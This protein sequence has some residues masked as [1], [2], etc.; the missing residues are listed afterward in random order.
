MHAVAVYARFYFIFHC[1]VTLLDMNQTSTWGETG[2]TDKK[3]GGH[4]KTRN[5]F[6]N[7]GLLAREWENL[8]DESGLLT[9]RKLLPGIILHPDNPHGK[10]REIC[11][12]DQTAREIFWFLTAIEFLDSVLLFSLSICWDEIIL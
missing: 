9:N 4:K 12:F 7:G 5:L 1:W 8:R 2:P 3:K 11:G 6:V 10:S